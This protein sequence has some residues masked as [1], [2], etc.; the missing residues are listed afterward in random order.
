MADRTFMERAWD[1]QHWVERKIAQIGK[2][3][4]A[5]VLRMARKPEPQ[6]FRHT[7]VVVLVGIA[8]VGGIGFVIYLF[9]SWVLKGVGA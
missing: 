4:Y 3:R 6:E 7:S 5:R 1:A 2:G 9:M 8:I